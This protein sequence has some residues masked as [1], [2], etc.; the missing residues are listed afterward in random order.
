[1][2]VDPLAIEIDN[3]FEFPGAE[4]AEDEE[5]ESEGGDSGPG[6]FSSDS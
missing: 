6:S 3:E 2:S 4:G 5:E 1:M